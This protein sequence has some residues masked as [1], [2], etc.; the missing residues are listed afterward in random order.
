MAK[1][2]FLGRLEDSAGTPEMTVPGTSLAAVIAML[3]AELAAAVRSPKVRVAINGVLVEA[4]DLALAGD[5][6]VAFLPPVSGG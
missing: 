4:D 2:V 3:P 6:E 1:L 5:D